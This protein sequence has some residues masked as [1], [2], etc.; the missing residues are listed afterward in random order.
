LTSGRK[1]DGG[2][3]GEEVNLL[4]GVPKAVASTDEVGVL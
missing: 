1:N 4:A 2:S 3:V